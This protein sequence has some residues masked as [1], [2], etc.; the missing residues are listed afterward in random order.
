MDKAQELIKN[1]EVYIKT[2]DITKQAGIIRLI[3]RT[4]IQL[5]KQDEKIL[6]LV[7]Q[8][9]FLE[10]TLAKGSKAIVGEKS[11]VIKLTDAIP[12][13]HPVM[14]DRFLYKGREWM[15]WA[16]PGYPKATHVEGRSVK[17]DGKQQTVRAKIED[18]EWLLTKKRKR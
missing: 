11:K 16:L 4:I 8:K 3:R 14:Y 1:L 18:C 9:R 5:K 13:H 12:T 17:I 2:L 7:K 10:E 15:V 6:T